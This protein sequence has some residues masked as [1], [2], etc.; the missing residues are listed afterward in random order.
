MSTHS[1]TSGNSARLGTSAL[2]HDKIA[3]IQEAF[4]V[5][6]VDDDGVLSRSELITI[7]RSLGLNPTA[8]ELEMMLKECDLDSSGSIDFKE[9]LNLVIRTP[10]QAIDPRAFGR[11]ATSL[12]TASS[13]VFSPNSSNSS[14]NASFL[15]PLPG[16]VVDNFCRL[17]VP[18]DPTRSGWISKENFMNE[19]TKK[20]D[21]LSADEWEDMLQS[22]ILQFDET[23]QKINY[24]AFIDAVCGGD[25]HL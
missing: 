1:S 14:F 20:G 16:V 13:G 11:A 8:E 17:F 10:E 22:G 7:M 5:M 6:D 23:G 24:R 15:E 25:A 4:G 9:F 2:T 3:E 19:M 21:K 12:S 18:F